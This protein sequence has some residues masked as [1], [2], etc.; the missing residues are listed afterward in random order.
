MELSEL[1]VCEEGVVVEDMLVE[2]VPFL[3]L[4]EHDDSI[5]VGVFGD[6]FDVVVNVAYAPVAGV[7]CGYHDFD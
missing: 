4:L 1:G 2:F 3:G 5:V 6:M 7:P